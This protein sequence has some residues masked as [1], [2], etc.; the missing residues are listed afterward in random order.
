[1]KWLYE[2]CEKK[3]WS[4]KACNDIE[5]IYRIKSGLS[6]WFFE[7]TQQNLPSI[8]D[9]FSSFVSDS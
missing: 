4:R 3:N 7:P 9:E 8:P 6:R 2:G 1:M 5:E